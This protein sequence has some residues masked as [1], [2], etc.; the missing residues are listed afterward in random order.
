V[1]VNFSHEEV[2]LPKATVL[3]MAD[4]SQV[5]RALRSLKEKLDNIKQFLPRSSRRKRGLFNIA[6]TVMKT[7]VPLRF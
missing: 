3:G 6:G 5:E 1:V 4:I 7:L 2:E